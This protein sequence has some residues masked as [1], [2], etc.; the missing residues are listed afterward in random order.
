MQEEGAE[1]GGEAEEAD[2]TNPITT[3]Y[4]WLAV[5]ACAITVYPPSSLFVLMLSGLSIAYEYI[6]HTEELEVDRLVAQ[7][8]SALV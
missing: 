4:C 8:V 1:E 6:T 5:F 7:L 3:M 2:H